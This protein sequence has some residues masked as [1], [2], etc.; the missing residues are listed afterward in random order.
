ML[1]LEW[2]LAADP[3]NLPLCRKYQERWE[4]PH[5]LDNCQVC[6][7]FIYSHIQLLWGM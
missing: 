4:E 7:A 2:H 6:T 5:A 3:D 1:K